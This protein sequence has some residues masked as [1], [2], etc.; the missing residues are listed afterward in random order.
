MPTKTVVTAASRLTIE[1]V[2]TTGS[3]RG[4]RHRTAVGSRQTFRFAATS[5]AMSSNAAATACGS[6][7]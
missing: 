5:L 3:G 6:V 2:S 4:E 1:A 7:N